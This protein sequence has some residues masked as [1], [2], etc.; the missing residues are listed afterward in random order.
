[1]AFIHLFTHSLIQCNLSWSKT[2]SGYLAAQNMEINEMSARSSESV[3]TKVLCSP[4]SPSSMPWPT[5]MNVLWDSELSDLS[6]PYW[7]PFT[8]SYSPIGLNISVKCVSCLLYQVISIFCPI[9]L[10]LF[11]QSW[12]IGFFSV[13]IPQSKCHQLC[14]AGPEHS[15]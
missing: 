6:L 15:G 2:L 7:M 12:K 11:S 5:Y 4:L 9:L 3:S 10:Q 14:E 1:M 13:L 8:M